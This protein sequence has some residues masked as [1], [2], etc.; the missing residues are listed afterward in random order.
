MTDS[1]QRIESKPVESLTHFLN[2]RLHF[3]RSDNF[4]DCRAV[5]LLL[6]GNLSNALATGVALHY[7]C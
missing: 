6:A 4:G 3:I 7:S 5:S 2:K 1:I